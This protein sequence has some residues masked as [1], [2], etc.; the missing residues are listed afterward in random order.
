[1]SQLPQNNETLDN[2][3]EY[4]KLYQVNDSYQADVDDTD[5]WP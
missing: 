1:M 4:P 3:P 2:S 5:D